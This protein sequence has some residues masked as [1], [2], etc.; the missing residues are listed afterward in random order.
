MERRI[1]HGKRMSSYE[2]AVM[3]LMVR[4]EVVN[5]IFKDIGTVTMPSDIANI[6]VTKNVGY[7][8]TNIGKFISA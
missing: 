1:R 8:F 4:V 3:D 6:K 2:E 5:G 7:K